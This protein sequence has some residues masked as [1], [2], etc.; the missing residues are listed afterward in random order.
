MTPV[1]VPVWGVLWGIGYVATG[2]IVVG[3]AAGHA[4]RCRCAVGVL[5]GWGF[6]LAMLPAC[7][8]ILARH[9]E[10]LRGAAAGHRAAPL[11]A[12]KS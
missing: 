10:K 1:A 7:L 12:R 9:R 8:L 5:A 4:A 6:G 3:D 11:L 2:Y